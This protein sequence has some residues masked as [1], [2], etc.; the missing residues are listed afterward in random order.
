MLRRKD[1]RKRI[2]KVVKSNTETEYKPMVDYTRGIF[3]EKKLKQILDDEK[4]KG[5]KIAK[6]EHSK[7]ECIKP[8]CF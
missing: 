4:Y 3:Y 8:T 5:A 2:D 1:L 6:F 7:K